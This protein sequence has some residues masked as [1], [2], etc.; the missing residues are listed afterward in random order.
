MHYFT[1]SHFSFRTFKDVVVYVAVVVAPPLVSF[2]LASGFWLVGI[3]KINLLGNVAMHRNCSLSGSAR[4]LHSSVGRVG[5]P[6]GPPPTRAG[7]AP[8]PPSLGYASSGLA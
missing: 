8:G 7:V 3:T 6:P 4:A 1:K 2:Y 5:A